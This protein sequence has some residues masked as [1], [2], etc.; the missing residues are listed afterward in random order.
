[1]VFAAFTCRG[2]VVAV[3]LVAPLTRARAF[4]TNLAVALAAARNLV[5]VDGAAAITA[6][7]PRPVSECDVGAIR[8]VGVERLVH[9]REKIEQPAVVQCVF[10]WFLALALAEFFVLHMWVSRRIATASR[11]GIDR[12]DP[13]SMCLPEI[14]KFQDN[15]ELAEIDVIQF[16][17]FGGDADRLLAKT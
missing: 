4:T 3:D 2:A 13:V 6:L 17:R 10:N 16:D 15:S 7:G 11:I 12:H 14:P 5:F 9:D 8:V 1:V